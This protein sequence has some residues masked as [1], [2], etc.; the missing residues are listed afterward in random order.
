MEKLLFYIILLYIL[1]NNFNIE[2]KYYMIKNENILDN[3][4][5][6]DLFLI[7]SYY[8]FCSQSLQIFSLERIGFR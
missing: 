2:Y 1:Y 7:E 8:H 3:I 5:H 6:F 4:F